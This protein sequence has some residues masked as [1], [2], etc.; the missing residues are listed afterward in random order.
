M[1]ET[2]LV[3]DE[4]GYFVSDSH[5]IL[6]RWRNDFSQLFNVRGFND[7]RQREIHTAEPLVPEPHPFEVKMAL[8]NLKRHKSPGIDQFPAEMIKAGGRTIRFEIC[9]LIISIW[10][11]EGLPEEW[12]ES[13]IIPNSNKCDKTIIIEA[14][15]FCQI[16]TK[17]YPTSCCESYLHMQKNYWGS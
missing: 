6:A 16:H 4:K 13:I 10:N 17:F 2:S 15:H 9:K 1:S 11:K 7:V 12:K 5:S 14:Y 3:K 8:E